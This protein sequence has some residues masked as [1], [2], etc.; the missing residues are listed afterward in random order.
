MET[1]DP[2]IASANIIWVSPDVSTRVRN[3]SRDSQ[4]EKGE[5]AL[6]ITLEKPA[7]KRSGDAWRIVMDCC[8]PILHLIDTR[9]SVPYAVKQIEELLGISCAFDQ[10]VQV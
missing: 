9:R 5:L 4:E 7:C 1:G 2:R 8:L 10:A 3:P 6:E